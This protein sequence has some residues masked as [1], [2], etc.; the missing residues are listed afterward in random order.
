M[1][2][3]KAVVEARRSWVAD[4]L[5]A[6]GLAVGT[7]VGNLNRSYVKVLADGMPH[8]A[9]VRPPAPP[10]L[11]DPPG[12]GSV[13]N[14]VAAVEHILP[15]AEAWEWLLV[16]LTALPLVLRRRCP[17][18]VYG[19]VTA[20]TLAVHRW[21][22]PAPDA[23]T[24]MFASGLAA[25]YA[26]AVYSPHRKAAVALLLAGVVLYPV[27]GLVADVDQGLVPLLVL[28]PLALAARVVDVWRRRAR[29]LREEREEALRRAVA[30]ERARI[31]RELHDVVTHNVSMMTIQAGAARKVLD[32][33]PE[34]A[35]E[36]MLAVETAGRA[37]MSE[38]RHVMGLLTMT[39][40]P[41]GAGPAVPGPSD[42]A[43][44]DL[45]PQPGPE[46]LA[47]L[48]ERVRAT[49]TPVELTVRGDA[50]AGTP[51]G[52]GLAVYRV[53]Q[54]ALTNAV[55]HA[56]GARV[57]VTVEHAPEELRVEVV[58]S[59]GRPR[60]GAAPGGGRGLIGLR[61]RLAVYG[62]TLHAGRRPGGG[63]EV[64]AVIPSAGPPARAGGGPAPGIGRE[65]A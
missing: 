17:L 46:R 65:D 37:A 60:A 18:A 10:A 39:D 14:P 38:L 49:G 52:V 8:P 24:V 19:V 35:R 27:C 54:E 44:P 58:D 2:W 41:P 3:M 12:V 48:V 56:E 16:L 20:A 21:G 9:P 22:E 25:G 47:D 11:P 1:R 26:A 45:A 43:D 32:T 13:T 30:G 40:D 34:Q 55:R 53:V 62:G 23:T 64:R 6:A 7:V 31:A 50:G 4:G 51:A 5:L 28:V 36:A 15:P 42:L 29:A 61:E 63:Y 33:A 59:G 57:A